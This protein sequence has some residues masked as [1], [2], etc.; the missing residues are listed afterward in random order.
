MTLLVAQCTC[1]FVKV[2]FTP[3]SPEVLSKLPPLH[4]MVKCNYDH[5]SYKDK[6]KK[7]KKA[8][9]SGN[10]YPLDPQ[11]SF[12]RTVLSTY[13]PHHPED[14]KKRRR[15]TRIFFRGGGGGVPLSG[16]IMRH[17]NRSRSALQFKRHTRVIRSVGFWRAQIPLGFKTSST[18][19][20]DHGSKGLVITGLHDNLQLRTQHPKRTRC[21]LPELEREQ[22]TV[23]CRCHHAQ[24]VS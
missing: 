24:G 22:T 21:R 5:L 13:I 9:N 12:P 23:L 10:K 17:C 18:A 8:F 4:L 20:I 19:I 3:S 6:K 14:K 11:K 7:K 15:R 1:T 16:R 2:L